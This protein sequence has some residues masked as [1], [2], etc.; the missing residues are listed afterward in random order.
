MSNHENHLNS[1][2]RKNEKKEGDGRKKGR[3]ER[4]AMEGEGGRERER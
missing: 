4:E 1:F 3:E 2:E